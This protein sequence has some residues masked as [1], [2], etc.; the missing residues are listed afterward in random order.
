MFDD[1][2]DS[3]F[4]NDKNG[5]INQIIKKRLT[6]IKNIRSGRTSSCI[7]SFL[8]AFPYN[9]QSFQ[10]SPYLNIDLF[11]YD[12]KIER[13]RGSLIESAKYLLTYRFY[14]KKTGKFKFKIDSKAADGNTL[15]KKR[16]Y[17][18]FHPQ[19]PFVITVQSSSYNHDNINFHFR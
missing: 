19:D 1:N 8:H 7:K 14:C 10:F 6:K 2:T 13:S 15:D 12:D 11:S 3:F 5:S 18:I 17:Y 16:V 9:S 4:S